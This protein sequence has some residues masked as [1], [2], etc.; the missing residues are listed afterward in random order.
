MS[1]KMPKRAAPESVRLASC[2]RVL[3]IAQGHHQQIT[4]VIESK[5]RMGHPT[6]ADEEVYARSAAELR[7][8]E[9]D[10]ELA[11]QEAAS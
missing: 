2:R 6:P 5:R 10:C 4:T 8:A 11:E 3:A 1:R 9:I 7:A